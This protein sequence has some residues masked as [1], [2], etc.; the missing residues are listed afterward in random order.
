MANVCAKSLQLY[1]TLC[2]PL[3]PT[4]HLCPWDSPGKK[5]GGLPF[6]S[7]GIFPTQGSNPCLLFWQVDSLPLAPPG[8]PSWQTDGETMGTETDFIFLGSKITAHC[9]CSHEIK[10]HLLLRRKTY[11]NLRKLQEIVKDGEAWHAAVHGVTKSWTW[12]S[13]WTEQNFFQEASVF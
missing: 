9:D 1:L 5:T 6:P 4:R 2:D 12:L 10:R 3:V 13:N 11:M 8:K 7:P